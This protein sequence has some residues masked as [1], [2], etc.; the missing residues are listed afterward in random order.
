MKYTDYCDNQIFNRIAL[1]IYNRY[2]KRYSSFL[3]SDFK[4][5]IVMHGIVALYECEHN[6]N[7]SICVDIEK[8]YCRICSN[9][10]S[11][12]FYSLHFCK[13]VSLDENISNDGELSILDTVGYED[14]YFFDTEFNY[15]NLKKLFLNLLNTYKNLEYEILLDYIIKKINLNDIRKKYSIGINKIKNI[16]REF[17]CK[18][19]KI[20]NENGYNINYMPSEDLCVP[21]NQKI[22]NL[23]KRKNNNCSIENRIGEF[24]IYKLLREIPISEISNCLNVPEKEINDIL[25]HL[26]GCKKLYLY[27]IQKL[28]VCFFPDYSL[29]KLCEV[30]D[31]YVS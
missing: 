20:L 10:M 7:F 24:Y 22:K 15:N 23:R 14:N 3:D 12:Y 8:E 4:Y 31:V 2:F 9:A 16:I 25:L 17:R 30:H 6:L 11:R 5:D 26:V 18:F 21:I 1:G 28:R 13:C 19:S 29:E 27:Q